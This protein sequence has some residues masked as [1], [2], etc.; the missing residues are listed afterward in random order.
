MAEHPINDLLS[1]T[2]AKLREVISADTII[3]SPIRLADD[4]TLI[5]VSQLSI[6]LAGG[7]SDF[8]KENSSAKFGG[9]TGAGVSMKPVCFIAYEHGSVRVISGNMAGDGPVAAAVDAIPGAVERITAF[10]QGI[11]NKKEE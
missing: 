2:L 1:T 11:K 7:G 4:V 6:G 9:G 5:P 3:G 8:G 10:I